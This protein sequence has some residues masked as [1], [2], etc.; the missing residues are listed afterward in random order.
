[1]YGQ[2]HLTAFAAP[3]CP[4]TF[5]LLRTLLAAPPAPPPG[6]I[7]ATLMRPD[8]CTVTAPLA[9][10]ATTPPVDPFQAFALIVPPACTVTAV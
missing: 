4:A 6:P 5:P 7:P 8:A 9:R 1:M 10:N 3:P 2:T